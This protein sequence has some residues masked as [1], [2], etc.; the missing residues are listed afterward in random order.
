MSEDLEPRIER[1]DNYKILNLLGTG[2]MGAVYRVQCLKTDRIFALKLLKSDSVKIHRFGHEFRAVKALDH[3]GIV[4]VYE[5]G[6]FASRPYFV[7][8]YI[9]GLP[10]DHLWQPGSELRAHRDAHQ[11]FALIVLKVAES[12]EFVHERRLIHRDIKPANILVDK[13]GQPRLM[14]FGLAITT[15]VLE[16]EVT[17]GTIAGSLS[18]MCPEQMLG[19]ELDVRAD[20]YS[21]G[22][23][24]FE[25][26]TGR[27]PFVTDNP[28]ELIQLHLAVDP[29]SVR[30]LNPEIPAVWDMLI[31]KLTAKSPR[32]RYQS[33]A[34]FARE[35][36]Q[37]FQ[38][39]GSVVSPT[40]DK[41]RIG[42]LLVPPYLDEAGS[43]AEIK[44]CL[45]GLSHNIP[46]VIFIRG[47]QGLGKSRLLAEVAQ[48]ARNQG[49]LTLVRTC[50]ATPESTFEGLE[51]LIKPL[52]SRYGRKMEQSLLEVIEQIIPK[53][54]QERNRLE[55]SQIRA[56]EV[57]FR[58]FDVVKQLLTH[59][60]TEN[61]VIVIF[62]DFQ[63][64]NNFEVQLVKNLIERMVFNMPREGAFIRGTV[65][66]LFII[67]YR[68]S[69]VST[70]WQETA[71]KL[72]QSYAIRNLVLTPLSEKGT[73]E[74]VKESMG[75]DQ[76][77]LVRAI[78]PRTGGVPLYVL[79][80][81]EVLIDEGLLMRHDDR[82]FFR[83]TAGET[84]NAEDITSDD[85]TLVSYR[86]DEIL[87][88]RFSL[89]PLEVRRIAMFA[90]VSTGPFSFPW[91]Q[92]LSGIER[93]E[94]L[95]AVDHLLRSKIL[96]EAGEQ[97]ADLDFRQHGFRRAIFEALDPWLRRDLHL[98]AATALEVVFG[99]RAATVSEQLAYHYTRG[100]ASEKALN[101]LFMAGDKAVSLF[102]HAQ[103]QDYFEQA[104][105]IMQRLKD[106]KYRDFSMA[107]QYMSGVEDLPWMVIANRAAANHEELRMA[108][109]MTLMRLV[110]EKMGSL[111]QITGRYNLALESFQEAYNLAKQQTN[112]QATAEIVLQMGQIHYFQKEFDIANSN[113]HEALRLFEDCRDLRGQAN[114]L[115]SLG[116]IAQRNNNL[117]QALGYYLRT[118]DL[119]KMTNN[120]LGV[121]YSNN[122]IGN[123]YQYRGDL[124]QALAYYDESIQL[125]KNLNQPL[126]LAYSLNNRAA[127]YTQ[128]L[129]FHIALADFRA[130]YKLRKKIGDRRG[131]VTS[132]I[133]V[134][135]IALLMGKLHIAHWAIEEANFCAQ[136]L[137]GAE[138]FPQIH[139][140]SL[141]LQLLTGSE[142]VI[143]VLQQMD[144]HN[145][146]LRFRVVIAAAHKADPK[147][148]PLLQEYIAMAIMLDNRYRIPE[149][150]AYVAFC[151]ILH[152]HYASA[153]NLLDALCR[154][155]CGETA[156]A[157]PGIR[158]VRALLKFREGLCTQAIKELTASVEDAR[159][160]SLMM[161]QL[162][163]CRVLARLYH[164]RGEV[165]KASE[166]VHNYLTVARLMTRNLPSD[167]RQTWANQVL[168]P[169]M[170]QLLPGYA[171]AASQLVKSWRRL[172]DY[173]DD[174]A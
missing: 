90:S 81:L 100:E 95:P 154:D 131:M 35:L 115:N 161:W 73:A 22:I 84:K 143:P 128:K 42:Y 70:N 68:D 55:I 43:L 145:A 8:D 125:L 162:R 82:W 46:E 17:E 129:Q 134:I 56:R 65:P 47:S 21:L 167:M 53:E 121:A 58:F 62:D 96:E 25:V 92:E 34:A 78:Y 28:R 41:P 150:L 126:G 19:Q 135:E 4:K 137:G 140:G 86:A 123:I 85:L 120:V 149:L 112:S 171:P 14:D 108:K 51:K 52:M 33:A 54:S 155:H 77:A 7:M 107:L 166:Q 127:I 6:M 15:G 130:G 101:Y 18:Y 45:K 122:N 156:E 63:W 88:R 76:T 174:V 27:L 1:I 9:D 117:D 26:L 93:D 50:S 83:T 13:T 165:G 132:L 72:Q 38:L 144:N 170:K 20:L 59:A 141:E 148:T 71:G 44:E 11:R 79:Q 12:L 10:L 169:R 152:Q 97:H 163:G 114:S 118:L 147:L 104:M 87:K 159:I 124:D 30:S 113:F 61:P 32:D 164:N 98:R 75:S 99:D 119:R 172:Q 36:V 151:L 24:L 94:L 106:L 31:G 37:A 139:L 40:E 136:Y 5:W 16:G 60:Y 49:V 157:Y 146:A 102:N 153:Q 173:A 138:Q 57:M 142:S 69:E 110:L 2:G 39:D 48:V 29:P 109:R 23:T 3:P 80:Y 103:A 66:I 105:E 116:V 91:L 89:L 133:N 168:S 67:A 160:Q 158:M 74:L 64:A 111:H